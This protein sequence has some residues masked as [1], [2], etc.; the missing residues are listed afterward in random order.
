MFFSIVSIDE[1]VNII[2]MENNYH[3]LVP[4]VLLLSQKDIEKTKLRL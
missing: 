2:V 4:G 1:F 3:T